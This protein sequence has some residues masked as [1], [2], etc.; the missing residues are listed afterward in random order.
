[1]RK[2]A[3][4]VLRGMRRARAEVATPE[5]SALLGLPGPDAEGYPL[6][7]LGAP[8]GPPHAPSYRLVRILQLLTLVLC[9]GVYPALRPRLASATAVG[10]APP[11]H[12]L[13]KLPP[14]MLA[15]TGRYAK[16]D[17]PNC[18]NAVSLWHG[19]TK[20][21]VWTS[22][23]ALDRRLRDPRLFRQ[24][25]PGERPGYGDVV[26]YR[27]GPQDLIEHGS[28]VLDSKWVWEKASADQTSP[29]Q[30]VSRR[31]SAQDYKGRT[32]IQ[33]FRRVD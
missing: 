30:V 7:D 22:W 5:E 33:H 25:A 21:A 31:E 32:V 3:A 9:V 2:P 15:R 20:R 19:L 18:L 23:R 16:K 24:L 26:V 29:W 8:S 14:K 10:Q 28:I 12:L 4:H 1:L 17:G 11:A 13:A 27:H 6:E